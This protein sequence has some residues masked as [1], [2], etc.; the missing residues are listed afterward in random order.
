MEWQRGSV[1]ARPGRFF[2]YLDSKR[3]CA[4]QCSINVERKNRATA[5]PGGSVERNGSYLAR[6]NAGSL[7][8]RTVTF[9]LVWWVV[10]AGDSD[11]FYF[12]VPAAILAAA[13]SLRLSPPPWPR[14]R[15]LALL[16]FVPY[17]IT[18][19]FTGG[20]DVARRALSRRMPLA[21]GFIR[22]PVG[23]MRRI[24]RKLFV[25]AVN[26]LPGTLAVRLH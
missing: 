10:S 1:L 22:Y 9:A 20:V 26:V 7:A 19:S 15:V 6:W 16:A 14:V 18:H 17:F 2:A 4:L 12:G 25:L 3:Q 24:E 21:P 13:L 8:M 5:R 11:S 23:S